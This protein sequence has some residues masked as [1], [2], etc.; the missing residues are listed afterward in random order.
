MRLPPLSLLVAALVALVPSG[1]SAHYPHDVA[2][3]LAISPDPAVPRLATSLERIDLDVLGRSDNGL[4]WSARL[5]GATNESRVS[6]GVF[7]S[8]DRLLLGTRGRG[9]LLSDDAGDTLS[10]VS[11]VSDTHLARVVAS[12]A[13]LA[14]GLVLVAGNTSVWRSTDGGDAWEV[15]LDGGGYSF[16]DLDLSPDFHQDGR[17]CALQTDALWCSDDFGRSWAQVSVPDFAFRVSVGADGRLWAAVRGEGLYASHDGGDTWVLAAFEGED[18]TAVAEL[19]DGLVLAAFALEA[20]WRSTDGGASWEELSI[21]E[22][23]VVQNQ[24]GVN[25]FDFFEGPDGAVYMTCWDG[26]ARS[27]DR[28]VSYSFYTTE[29]LENTHS[30]VLTVGDD[31]EM[32]AWI[33][34]YGGGP[35]V[36]DVRSHAAETF[37][38]LPERYTRNTPSTRGW[39]RDGA[40]LF[41][42]GYSTWVTTDWGESWR[43]IAADPE[44]DGRVL[45]DMDVKGVAISPNTTDDDFVLTSVGDVAMLFLSSEDLGT[46]WLTG[47]QDPPCETDGFA[48]AISPWWPDDQRAWAA[49]GGAIYQS[50]DRG[51]HWLLVGDTGAAFVFRISQRSD[52][53]L[54]LATSDGLW[55]LDVEGIARIAFD[56][57]LVVGVEA[58][59]VDGDETVFALVPALGWYRSDDGGDTWKE[60]ERPT[61]DVP[62]MVSL[63]PDFD[64]D[65][66]V[67]VAGYGGAWASLDRGESWGSIYAVEVYESAH[68]AWKATGDWSYSQWLDASGRGVSTTDQEGATLTLNFRGVGVELLAP[69]DAPPGLLAVVLD[70]EEP[71]AVEL[72][73]AENRAWSATGLDNDWHKLT[74]RVDVGTA[75]VDAAR[76]TRLDVEPI[77]ADEAH[78]PEPGTDGACGCQRAGAVLLAVPIL[79]TCRRRVTSGNAT[80]SAAAEDPAGASQPP[81]AVPGS[82]AVAGSGAG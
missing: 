42:Q 3:W 32:L 63:S 62:R 70:G 6:T 54:L 8:F 28:G 18:V 38:D 73:P 82:G 45:L 2:Y 22:I 35:I 72:P 55:R 40:A 64:V 5:V 25:F 46:T 21:L 33:G 11:A 34:S 27:D 57:S 76:V 24:D 59:P 48:V 75:T 50:S 56:G 49:C 78:P 79:A 41:D 13:V 7:V 43:K 26:V 61:L 71:V 20:G 30:V 14:D 4:D 12:P 44:V 69:P 66:V 74:V 37:P 52:G 10:P 16:E 39:A 67:A 80:R 29:R 65:G 68:E 77:A 1:A 19:S 47:E 53:A 31:R 36:T 51:A 23:P 60:L 58:A 81:Q 15:T 17:A 9:L